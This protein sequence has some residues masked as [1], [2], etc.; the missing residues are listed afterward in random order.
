MPGLPWRYRSKTVVVVKAV[1]VDISAVT[2]MNCSGYGALVA[3]RLA[4]E[5]RGGSL[6]ILN[7]TGQPANLLGLIA[8]IESADGA[9]SSGHLT[10]HPPGALARGSGT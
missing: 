10:D 1:A 4:L 2:L 6:S 9:T 7:P 5:Q 8:G 3:A